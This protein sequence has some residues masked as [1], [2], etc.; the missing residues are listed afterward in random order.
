[1]AWEWVAP[2]V[3]GVTAV[4]GVFFTWLT[5]SQGRRQVERLARRAEESAE[6]NRAMQ[7]RREAYFAALRAAD[8]DFRRKRYKRQGKQDKLAEIDHTWPKGER[9]RMEMDAHIAV[10]TFG[11]EQVRELLGQWNATVGEE[12]NDVGKMDPGR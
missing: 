6:R 10:E 1:M 4:S 12:Q 5:G 7:E 9:A 3:T 8:L 11:S 2:A